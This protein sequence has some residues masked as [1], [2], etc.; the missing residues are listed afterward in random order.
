MKKFELVILC[1]ITSSIAGADIGADLRQGNRLLRRGKPEEALTAYEKALVR[2][3][4]NPDIHYNMGRAF[5][6]MKKYDEA[7]SEFQ[8]GL[9]KKNK[10]YQA[11]TFYNIGNCQF[12]KGTIDAAIEAYK[13]TLLLNPKD[14]AAKQN[15]ELCLNLKQQ[16]QDHSQND[17]L[18]QQQKEKQPQ[19]QAQQLER[20]NAERVLQ[21]LQDQ[22]KG[23]LEKSKQPEKKQNVEKDW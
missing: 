3:P 15:L 16:M 14:K 19:P 2:E 1:L 5:H 22:E 8:L 7:I 10:K 11:N 4:D 9:L 18:N 12:R 17:S 6:E 13:T 21:A 23:N 20:E